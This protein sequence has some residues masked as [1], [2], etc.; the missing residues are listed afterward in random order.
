MATQ[1]NNRG[2][3]GRIYQSK[4]TETT[5]QGAA[6][7]IGF[8]PVKAASS[9]K[10]M[11]DYK[12]AIVADGQTMSRELARQQQAE[13]TALAA[14][15]KAD[16]GAMK[17]EQIGESAELKQDQLFDKNVMKQDHTHQKGIMALEMAT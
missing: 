16:A 1:Q 7:S 12:A 13:N 5:Y 9:E 14:Q 6:R 8:N 4:P 17:M 15:Q 10:A 11:R 3:D 2:S